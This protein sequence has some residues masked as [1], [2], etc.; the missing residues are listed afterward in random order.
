M[1]SHGAPY[2]AATVAGARRNAPFY[3]RR[4][5]RGS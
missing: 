1:F 2:A 4:I 3:A 5:A